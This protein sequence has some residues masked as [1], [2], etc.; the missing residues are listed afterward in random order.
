MFHEAQKAV[1]R[2][3]KKAGQPIGKSEVR[4]TPDRKILRAK[5]MS[6]EILELTEADN[7]VDEIDALAD[8]I[9]FAVGTFVEMGV[10]GSE[11]FRLVHQANIRKVIYNVKNREDGKV[12]K[13]SRWPAPQSRIKRY[14]DWCWLE[15][16]ALCEG[17]GHELTKHEYIEG[18]ECE[19]CLTGAHHNPDSG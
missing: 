2:F 19:D 5:W 13:P 4:L 16:P 1:R 10:N 14:L 17:C 15:L 9:Y 6:E 3:H 11:I 18:D 7:L 12:A 8:L